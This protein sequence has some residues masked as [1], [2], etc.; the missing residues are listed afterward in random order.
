MNLVH[1][2]WRS[3]LPFQLFFLF[4]ML[5]VSRGFGLGR[6]SG[7]SCKWTLYRRSVQST[8]I[9][10][11]VL[12][13][14]QRG[15][16]RG[17]SFGGNTNVEGEEGELK[18]F[19]KG[20][21]LESDLWP[22]EDHSS[23]SGA[24]SAIFLE[25]PSPDRYS[26]INKDIKGRKIAEMAS[27]N[28]DLQEKDLKDND[29]VNDEDSASLDITSLMYILDSN[30]KQS[31]NMERDDISNEEVVFGMKKESDNLKNVI[32]EKRLNKFLG[33]RIALRRALKAVEEVECVVDY[34]YSSL[35][36]FE[37]SADTGTL[38]NNKDGEKEAQP[39]CCG[40][41]RFEADMP[42]VNLQSEPEPEPIPIPTPEKTSITRAVD[43]SLDIPI[44]IDRCSLVTSVGNIL[45]DSYGAPCLPSHVHGSISHKDDVALGMATVGTL[46]T[47]MNLFVRYYTIYTILQSP[48]VEWTA[49]ASLA[50]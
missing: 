33:G 50:L 25:S 13:S 7:R 47:V 28:L 45:S 27:M 15:E 48:V 32:N 31:Y 46:Y 6:L 11:A 2:G 22:E 18:V 39:E 41:G 4:V 42:L 20:L 21:F 5:V 8:F 3:L 34:D 12:S 29:K 30:R 43:G 38:E 14:S 10:G 24:C 17:E 16:G 35:S 37:S 19:Y 9:N 44:N 36:A 1:S 49:Y 26:F 23:S 40:H